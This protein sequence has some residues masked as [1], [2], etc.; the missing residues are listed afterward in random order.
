MARVSTQAMT[1][2][3]TAPKERIKTPDW[4]QGHPRHRPACFTADQWDLWRLGALNAKTRSALP[5]SYC[6]DCTPERQAVMVT[7]SHCQH[8]S[9]HFDRDTDGFVR[10]TRPEPEASTTTPPTNESPKNAS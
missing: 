3:S 10:G 6:E 1:R 9:T 4:L 7:T 8:P 5:K 2:A